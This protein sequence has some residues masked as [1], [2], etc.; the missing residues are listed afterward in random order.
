[1]QKSLR[2][3]LISVFAALHATLYFLS[4][5]TAT[6][7]FTYALWRNWAI[8]LEPLEGIILGPEAGFYAALIGS[9]A[10]RTMRPTD[11]ASWIY[12]VIAE[13]LGVLVCAFLA[14][15]RW[16]SVLP[17]YAIMLIAYLM[18]PFFG[19][20][21][22][23]SFLAVLD[24]LAAFVLIYPVAK[25]GR[26]VFKGNVQRLSLSLVLISFVGIATDALV[27]VFLLVPAGLWLMFTP[28]PDVAYEIFVAG[29]IGSY[30]E[31][32]L[33]VIV[34]FAGGVPLLVALR[35]IPAFLFS[36]SV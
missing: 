6:F 5:P 35:K 19:M 13:P 4:P 7:F 30:I 12:G 31:D 32:I 23:L 28:F 2:I 22:P 33:V 21:F 34:S 18:H 20:W 25:I 10:G 1:M 36:E 24:S 16:K 29:A 14:R 9:V 17:I 27:R 3:G 15:G 11:P 8:Y 26:W